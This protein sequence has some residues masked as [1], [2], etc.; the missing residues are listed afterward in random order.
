LEINRGKC[1]YCFGEEEKIDIANDATTFF[2]GLPCCDTCYL[3]II[4]LE[5]KIMDVLV[6]DGF[7]EDQ[8]Y[9]NNKN[10]QMV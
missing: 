1:H 10:E 2:L 6:K 9:S 3:E 7:F 4:D 8:R 5:G